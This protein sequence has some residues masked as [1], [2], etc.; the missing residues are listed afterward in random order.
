MAHL[1][2]RAARRCARGCGSCCA[3]TVDVRHAHGV[4]S[5]VGIG[6]NRLGHYLVGLRMAGRSRKNLPK[7]GIHYDGEPQGHN[8]Q[9]NSR[10]AHDYHIDAEVVGNTRAHSPRRRFALAI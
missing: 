5:P 4:K 6:L 9:K 1:L 2:V 7:N 3:R 10:D 8:R